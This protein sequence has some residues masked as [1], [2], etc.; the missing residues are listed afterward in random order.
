MSQHKGVSQNPIP[1][2]LQ[3]KL[4]CQDKAKAKER[5]QDRE[6]EVYNVHTNYAL[7]QEEGDAPT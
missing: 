2:G 4:H 5:I 1:K 7:G 3:G 6:K